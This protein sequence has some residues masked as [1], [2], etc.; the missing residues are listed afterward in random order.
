[1]KKVLLGILI[2]ATFTA[3]KKEI[4]TVENSETTATDSVTVPE[5]NEPT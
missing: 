4:T 3:C 2:A 5:S 1:M